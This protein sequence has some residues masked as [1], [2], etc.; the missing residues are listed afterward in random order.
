MSKEFFD[1]LTSAHESCFQSGQTTVQAMEPSA[2]ESVHDLYAGFRSAPMGVRPV[3][4]AQMVTALYD[5]L[6]HS[7]RTEREATVKAKRQA[8]AAKAREAR[9]Q[10]RL[11]EKA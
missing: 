5:V 8:N 6:Q 3:D 11:E 7:Y 1:W 4:L 2:V 10:K 9:A